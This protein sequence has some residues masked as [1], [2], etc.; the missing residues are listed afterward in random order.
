MLPELKI[1]R[2]RMKA[3]ATDP[4]LF[5]TDLAEYLVKKGAPFREAHEIVGKLVAHAV[6]KHVSLDQITLAE[7]KKLSPLL[8]VDVAKVFDARCSLAQ[9]QAIGAPSPE[10]VATQI[11]RW[12]KKLV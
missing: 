8:D 5:A 4:D 10:N 12:R 6:A 7:M 2:K 11:K 3:A 9:R 1:N